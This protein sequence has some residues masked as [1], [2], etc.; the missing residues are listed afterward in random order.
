VRESNVCPLPT[1]STR[2]SANAQVY[3]HHLVVRCGQA[4]TT[5]LSQVMPP[6]EADVARM[7]RERQA[8][9]PCDGSQPQIGPAKLNVKEVVG[10]CDAG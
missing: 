3:A 5:K 8:R 7:R 9:H 2:L 10:G 4:D 1:S 6:A